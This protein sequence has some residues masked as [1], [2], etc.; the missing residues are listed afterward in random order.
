[1][2]FTNSRLN[3]SRQNNLSVDYIPVCLQRAL[4]L[5]VLGQASIQSQEGEIENHRPSI[6]TRMPGWH[7]L[8]AEDFEHVNSAASTWSWKQDG[9]YCSGQP[10]SVL[11]T[12]KLYTNFEMVMEWSHQKAG[13]NSGVFVGRHRNLLHDS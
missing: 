1:M 6:D 5:L 7:A 9:L 10:V 4:L 13:G 8:E 3:L 11:R 2:D 12:K